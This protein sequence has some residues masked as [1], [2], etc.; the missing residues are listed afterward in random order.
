M[1]YWLFDI[2]S[3]PFVLLTI[4]FLI[5][6]GLVYSG[7]TDSFDQSVVLYFSENVGNP[8]LDLFMQYVTESGDVFN[9]LMFGILIL[10]IPRTRITANIIET[11]ILFIK[12]YKFS[13]TFFKIYHD[14][15]QKNGLLDA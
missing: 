12:A 3:R 1:K 14:L 13:T 4:S 11:K 2:R 10:L 5:L 9:M 8:T 7:V 15:Y 6:T